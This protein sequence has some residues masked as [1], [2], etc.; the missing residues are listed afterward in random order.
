MRGHFLPASQ[1]AALSLV[2]G[3]RVTEGVTWCRETYSAPVTQSPPRRISESKRVL[4]ESPAVSLEHT[5]VA[6]D[7]VQQLIAL[8]P[9]AWQELFDAYYRKLYRFAYARTGDPHV[10]EEIASE[11]FAAAAQGIGRYRDRGAPIAAWLYRI[12]R[13]VTADHLERKRRRPQTSLDATEL[14]VESPDLAPAVEDSTD[15][16]RSIAGLTREQQEVITLRFYNDCSVSEAAQALG[17]SEG[18]VKLLQ[19]RALAALRKQLTGKGR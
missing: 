2:E 17:K 7:S 15:L 13:N 1:S 4:T 19:H 12:C 10:A 11:V 8:E 5:A 6:A 18:A 14:D 9:M 16:A 3:A